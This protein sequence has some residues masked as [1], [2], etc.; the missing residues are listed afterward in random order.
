MHQ[1]E[2]SRLPFC[3]GWSLA[4]RV[5]VFRGFYRELLASLDLPAEVAGAEALLLA[6]YAF[7]FAFSLFL[8]S[9]FRFHRLRSTEAV[10]QI[11]AAPLALHTVCS[12]LRQQLVAELATQAAAAANNVFRQLLPLS[13]YRGAQSRQDYERGVLLLLLYNFVEA[14][15]FQTAAA[16]GAGSP[17]QNAALVPVILALVARCRSPV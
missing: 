11:A 12:P 14:L 16:D 13:S 9:C 7:W 8:H 4:K 3:E 1:L 10:Q 17:Q 6:R 2:D 5:R 15:A